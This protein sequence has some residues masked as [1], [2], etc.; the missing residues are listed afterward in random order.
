MDFNT[1]WFLLV[2]VLF[3]GYVMLDGFDLGVGMLHLFTKTDEHRRFMLNSIGPVWDG[4]EV[5]LVTGG[6]A[7]FGAFPEV[8]A[9]AFSAFY[10]PFTLLVIALIFRGVAIEFRSKMPSPIWRRFWDWSFALGSFG[11]SFLLGVTMA[12]I[13]WGIPLDDRHNYTGTFMDFIH[14]YGLWGGLLS[15]ALFMMHGSLYTV[16]KT[17]GELQAQARRWVIFSMIFF[18]ISFLI[19]N[20]MSV[21]LVPHIA[22]ALEQKPYLLHLMIGAMALIGTLPYWVYHQREG[23][24]FLVSCL[25]IISLMAILGLTLYP[26]MIVSYPG[27]HNTINIYNGSSSSTT[28]QIM[29]IIAALGVPLVLAY[30]VC[31]YWIFRGKVKA[32]GPNSY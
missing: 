13:L 8:Y 27:I 11:S 32:L 20:L 15:V 5:W 22:Y 12:N 31:I 23:M 2:G 19:F 25:S 9:T 4:N 16:L 24:G 21:A 1:L 26:H 18:L 14:G 29:A 6:G 30:T 17:E 28:L 10:M 7:L 3:T